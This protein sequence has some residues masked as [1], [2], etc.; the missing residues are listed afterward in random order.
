MLLVIL[1]R[2]ACHF[3][4]LPPSP[5]I[6]YHMA[7]FSISSIY[8]KN[9]FFWKFLFMKLGCTFSEPIFLEI[10]RCDIYKYTQS[11]PMKD[12]V[13]SKKSCQCIIL[14]YM[15]Y[16][17]I[18][19]LLLFL[20]AWFSWWLMKWYTYWGTFLY[21]FNAWQNCRDWYDWRLSL[22]VPQ[23]SHS[24]RQHILSYS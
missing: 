3:S 22:Y 1:F 6:L 11:C 9:Y 13:I 24:C 21:P 20:N 14:K 16:M 19:R 4:K 15:I 17:Y 8:V 18:D 10:R 7:S 23:Q 12:W 2:I 5:E